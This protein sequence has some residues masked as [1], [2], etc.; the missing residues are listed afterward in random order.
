MKGDENFLAQIEQRCKRL[1]SLF[2]V[3]PRSMKGHSRMSCK[4]VS[5]GGFWMALSSAG[6]RWERLTLRE[7]LPPS[8]G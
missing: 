8:A 3:S 1:W 4:V 6:D 5:G 7:R 2:M